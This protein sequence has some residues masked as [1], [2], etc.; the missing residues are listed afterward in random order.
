MSSNHAREVATVVEVP[1]PEF[2]VESGI[3]TAKRYEVLQRV[4]EETE[5]TVSVVGTAS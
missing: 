4:R 2:E 3:M 5:N 1:E